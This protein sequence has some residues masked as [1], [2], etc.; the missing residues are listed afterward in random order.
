[1]M[2]NKT[3]YVV[4]TEYDIDRWGIIPNELITG[5]MEK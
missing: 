5:I 1:M 4:V 3:K 2:I